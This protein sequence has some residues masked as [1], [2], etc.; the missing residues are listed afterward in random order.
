MLYSIAKSDISARCNW[1]VS[2]CFPVSSNIWSFQRCWDTLFLLS[3]PLCCF[4]TYVYVLRAQLL[5]KQSRLGGVVGYHVSL[6]HWR[7]WDRAP[8]ESRVFF[9]LIGNLV[10]SFWPTCMEQGWF[11]IRYMLPIL[12]PLSYSIGQV[13]PIC[14][15]VDITYGQMGS[16]SSK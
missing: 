4:Y 16:G 7:S 13:P 1:I 3:R 14:L 6:T 5:N 15:L 12:L 9:L 2:F 11:S 8:A 10:P